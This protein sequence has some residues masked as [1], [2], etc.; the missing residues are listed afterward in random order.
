MPVGMDRRPGLARRRG[1][2][3]DMQAVPFSVPS[4]PMSGAQSPQFGA[5]ARFPSVVF[6]TGMGLTPIAAILVF[7]SE[8]SSTARISAA[9]AILGVALVGLSV[10]MRANAVQPGPEFEALIAEEIELLRRDVRQ[11]ITSA[12]TAS[13]ANLT[14]RLQLVRQHLE[15]AR[16]PAEPVRG[17]YPP[18]AA[19]APVATGAGSGR[20][21]GTGRGVVKHT[22]TVQVT[23]QTIV[24]RHD[25]AGTT[26]TASGSAPVR[27]A[28]STRR[29]EPGYGERSR[30][31]DGYPERGREPEP[32]PAERAWAAA[33]RAES[34]AE[35]RAAEPRAES[36]AAEPRV[37]SWTDQKLRERF[38]DP[39]R[40]AARTEPE[41]GA[42]ES[43]RW[44][45]VG[46]GDRWAEVRADEHGRELHVGERRAAVRSDAGGTSVRIE[47]RWAAVRRQEA[48]NDEGRWAEPWRTGGGE[49]RPGARAVEEPALERDRAAPWTESTWERR[50]PVTSH[51]ALPAAPAEPASNW[52]RA[53][54]DE[55]RREPVVERWR[56]EEGLRTDTGSHRRIEFDLSDER[57]R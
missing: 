39:S 46:A 53:W 15:A 17:G 12:V 13:H 27:H 48:R 54:A 29:T 8:G 42:A 7:L 3:R 44:S 14:E 52:T 40:F 31:R 4:S 6:W 49:P 2:S 34:R 18:V 5:A 55:P 38:G 25:E 33:P 24:D 9:V 10:M 35:S 43:G 22:E 1:K 56:R 20:A 37:E 45:G 23:R 51:A 28:A 19:T 47:D 26:Y 21:T 16:Q 41:A 57:W 32:E 36:W 11:D 30:P 50:G